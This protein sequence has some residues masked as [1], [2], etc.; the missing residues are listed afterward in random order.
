MSEMKCWKCKSQ[1]T[2]TGYYTYRDTQTVEVMKWPKCHCEPGWCECIPYWGLEDQSF[3]QVTLIFKCTVCGFQ[4]QTDW[5][6]IGLGEI[7]QK[8]TPEQQQQTYGKFTRI[9]A[10]PATRGPSALI[11]KE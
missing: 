9:A 4:F 11:E 3:T 1:A 5:A 8:L 10:D 2:Q 7:N 6:G